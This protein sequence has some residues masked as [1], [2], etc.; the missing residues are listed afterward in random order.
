[1]N[2]NVKELII[3]S[4]NRLWIGTKK[5]GLACLNLHNGSF[6]HFTHDPNKSNSILGNIIF[7]LYED[8]WGYSGWV[9]EA[10]A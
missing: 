5:S 10:K 8:F 2:I 1:M 3:S 7:S 4:D 6:S 9:M